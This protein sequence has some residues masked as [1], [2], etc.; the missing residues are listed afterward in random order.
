MG[1]RVADLG[2]RVHL[3][4]VVVES[5]LGRRSF[6]ESWT[7]RLR[8]AR[9]VRA[10]RPL[11]HLGSG[12]THTT[13][14]ALLTAAVLWCSEGKRE[15]A[16]VCESAKERKEKTKVPRDGQSE[17]PAPTPGPSPNPGGGERASG[18]GLSSPSPRIGGAGQ[19]G[20]AGV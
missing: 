19:G 8:W 3:S 16:R 7:R 6:R 13:A 9:T 15:N 18:R 12:L 5:V 4:S 2:L 14:L 10:C 11:G 17:T 1:K 20:G